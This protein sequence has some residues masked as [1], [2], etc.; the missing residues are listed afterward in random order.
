LPAGGLAITIDAFGRGA[1]GL[2]RGLGL[3]GLAQHLDGG[4]DIA[5]DLDERLLALHHAG[6]G[7]LAQFLHQCC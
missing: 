2:L 4:L 3:T 7:A 6:A 5:A 1:P